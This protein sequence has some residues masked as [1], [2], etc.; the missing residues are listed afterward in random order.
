M[1]VKLPILFVDDD[2][3]AASMLRRFGR[4]LPYPSE[5]FEDSQAALDAFAC[6]G[7]CLVVTD[8]RMPGMD[9]FE[10]LHRLKG[11]DPEVPI[12]VVTGHSSLDN[13]IHAMKAG[14]A[15]FIKKP[16]DLD[17]MA[18]VIERVLEK[19]RLEQENA[20]LRR[21]MPDWSN[22]GMIGQSSAMEQVFARI[23]K[24]ADIACN[25]IISGESGTGKELVA[26]A[27]HQ[28]GARREKPF[29]VIDCGALSDT[30]LESELFGHEKGAFTGAVSRKRGL[31]EAA[32]GGTVFLDEICNI[33]DAMQMKLLRVIQ[34]GQLTRVGGLQ[35][36][37]IDVRFIVATNRDLTQMVK[38]GEFR[39]DLF[40]RLNVVDI[41]LPPLRERVEDIPRLATH[42]LAELT[43]QYA[44][45]VPGFTPTA[46][47]VLSQARWPGNIRELRNVIERA[48][49]M[50][51]PGCPLD[52]ADLPEIE[53]ADTPG[54]NAEL[55]AE[56]LVTLAE[57]ESRYIAHVLR[58]VGGERKRAADILGIDKTTLWRKLKDLPTPPGSGLLKSG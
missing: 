33:S 21:A 47:Q 44:R 3:V 43:Q 40:H 15:D 57:L 25:V 37:H 9:G 16:F 10:L 24:V 56:S 53:P 41:R 48:V 23:R 26:Q 6:Q 13:A 39:H 30:L 17:E 1:P 35:P 18:L 36:V 32:S 42:F 22:L 50:A 46:L 34:E 52:I 7:A 4:M 8:L 2:P 11:I 28:S 58:L 49:I 54:F 51:E 31:L 27:I 5:V 20:L 19:S 29:V 45:N 38:Q 55:P 12:L 14:A